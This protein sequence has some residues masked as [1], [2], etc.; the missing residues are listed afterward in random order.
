VLTN[1]KML[2]YHK[3]T[4]LLLQPQLYESVINEA[5]LKLCTE[6]CIGICETY[7]RLHDY[8]PVA[9]STLSLQTVFLAGLTLV[10]CTW[11]APASSAVK[12]MSALS[13]CSIML[14]I[15]TERWPNIRRYRD[16]FEAIKRTVLSLV[17]DDKHQPRKVITTSTTDVW[18]SLQS[19]DLDMIENINREDLEQMIGDMTG[20]RMQ[21][22]LW[23]D[24]DMSMYDTLELN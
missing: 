5:Y 17:T 19:F 14:Y 22:P 3:C 6:A 24:V 16:A 4:R 18:S 10:F 2:H 7:R 11:Q 1:L 12:N 13:D 9:F 20:E 15:M 21:F 23:N 8:F